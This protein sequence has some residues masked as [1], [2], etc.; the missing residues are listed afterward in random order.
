MKQ[1]MVVLIDKSEIF[2]KGLAKVLESEADIEVVAISSTVEEAFQK[3]VD[4]KADITIC[5]A[6]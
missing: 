1:I 3:I 2:V 6:N 4:L 5:S